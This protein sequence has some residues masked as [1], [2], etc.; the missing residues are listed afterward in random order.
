[1]QVNAFVLKAFVKK[2]ETVAAEC[3]GSALGAIDFQMLTTTGKTGHECLLPLP[4]WSIGIRGLGEM[5]RVDVGNAISC[6]ENLEGVRDRDGKSPLLAQK[7][8]EKWGTHGVLLIRNDCGIMG[9]VL[10]K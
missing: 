5:V 6:G 4:W 2:T 1:V 9:A 3:G 8:R 7:T 10:A